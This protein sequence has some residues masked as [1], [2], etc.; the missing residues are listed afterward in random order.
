MSTGEAKAHLSKKDIWGRQ[1]LHIASKLGHGE[2]ISKL[3]EMGSRSDEP[4]DTGKCPVDYF[5]QRLKEEGLESAVQGQPS[6]DSEANGSPRN[7]SETEPKHLS[8]EKLDMFLKFA[9]EPDSRYSNG[10]TFLHF[11][12]E[13]ASDENIRTFASKKEFDVEAQDDDGRT[14]LH[15]AIL[16]GRPDVANT[17]I[18]ELKAKRSAKDSG[19]TTALMLAVQKNYIDV[20]RALLDASDPSF[21]NEVDDDKK[22]AIHYVHSREMVD[23]L[24]TN[25][26]NMLATDSLGRTALHTAIERKEN[27]ALYLLGLEDPHQV[28][29]EPFDDS[30]ESLLVTACRCGFSEIVSEILKR[31]PN[32]INTEDAPYEQPPIS[33]AC[34]YGHSDVVTKL[35]QHEGSE[36]VEVNKTGGWR[37]ST[38]L[39]FAATLEDSKCLA[40]LLQQPST[41][42]RCESGTGE[43]PLGLAACN[44]RKDAARMLLQ[45]HRT[46][47]KDRLRYVQELTS[48]SFGVFP[49]IIGGILETLGDTSFILEYF[50]WL[51]DHTAAPGAQE[52]INKF[53]VDLKRGGWKKLKTPYHVAILL[54]DAEFVQILK[55][56]NAP[57]GGLDEDNWS[58]VDYAKRFDRDGTSLVNHFQPLNASTEHKHKKPTTL[59]WTSSEPIAQVTSC[60]TEGHD[61]CSKVH[62]VEVIRAS[63]GSSHTCIRSDHSIP[64]SEKY[65][66]FEAEVLQDSACRW[67]GIGFCGLD[68][69]NDQ[70]PGWFKGSWGYHGDDGALFIESG[71][72]DIFP[73]SDFGDSGKFESGD[74]V[75]VC[76]NV[77]TGQ[78]FCTRNGKKLNME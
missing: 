29:T 43:T 26:C 50:L 65:F 31:W 48:S 61:S 33:W 25:E 44:D 49:G 16:S 1:A 36:R 12:V 54:G 37:K 22:A 8:E 47:P 72:E 46:T 34:E 56:Q 66:Y 42:L 74:V 67:L 59:I 7:E 11:A 70:M 32:I 57:Q 78:G 60:T 30:K 64:P 24:I 73:S 19:N 18:K 53:V 10:K 45:D 20:A 38:P 58:L 17:L 35:L 2:I 28:Q 51:F 14:P 9:M 21:V 41:E 27:V 4:D 55:E 68:N 77:N 5:V 23:L 71:T 69:I 3:L 63:T 13:V 52:S 76:L 39:H 62:D 40:L 6:N 15:Y 75:G